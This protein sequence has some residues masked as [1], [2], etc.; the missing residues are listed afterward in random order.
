MDHEPGMRPHGAPQQP[1]CAALA[2]EHLPVHARHVAPLGDRQVCQ[3]ACLSAHICC[4]PDAPGSRA[5]GQGVR[6]PARAHEAAHAARP[7]LVLLDWVLHSLAPMALAA[8]IGLFCCYLAPLV[9]ASA[10]LRS[11]AFQLSPWTPALP[12]GVILGCPSTL[13]A[14]SHAG[15][16]T[17]RVHQ[18][19]AL[20]YREAHERGRE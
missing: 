15:Q 4:A 18:G 9:R 13:L 6:R 14:K 12:F 8:G 11:C 1:V 3:D 7:S 17:P 19:T 5:A 20:C 10:S 2:C 16:L